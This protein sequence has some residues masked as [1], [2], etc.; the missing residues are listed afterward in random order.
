[1]KRAA[2]DLLSL[3]V[4]EWV[5]IHFPEGGY[6]RSKNGGECFQP[7]LKLPEGF[8]A[9]TAGADVS[10]NPVKGNQ[11]VISWTAGAAPARVGIYTF[12][13]SRLINTTVAPPTN[14]YVWDLTAGGRRM[15][16]G[17][18]LVVV[19]VDGRVYRRRLF[20]TRPPA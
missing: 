9:G 6:A 3:G 1:M 4:R 16:N 13:G 18:Y 11:V 17:A 2:H 15:P 8:V 14:E 12:A 5:V 19:E 10:E 20:V 7:S